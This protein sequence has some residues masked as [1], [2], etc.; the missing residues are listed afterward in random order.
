VGQSGVLFDKHYADQ[1]ERYA[2]GIYVPLYLSKKDVA[3]H[4]K[5]TLTLEPAP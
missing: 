1:S 2:E 3:K 4:T 5:S